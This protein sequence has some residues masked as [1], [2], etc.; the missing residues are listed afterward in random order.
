LNALRDWA[1]TSTHRSIHAFIRHNREGDLSMSQVNTLFRLYHHGPSAMKDFATHL[2]ITKAAVSQMINQLTEAGLITRTTD[3]ND[4]RVKLITLT[5]K[6]TQ[7]VEVSKQARHAWINELVALFTP[8]E[9][10]EILPILQLLNQHTHEL[11][12]EKRLTR[13]SGEALR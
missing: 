13:C 8:Q 6:G 5:E 4:R 12:E 1:E 10:E 2:G 7:T 3:A 11:T 9:K